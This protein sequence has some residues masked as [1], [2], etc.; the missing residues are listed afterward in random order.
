MAAVAGGRVEVSGLRRRSPQGDAAFADLLGRMGCTVT[1]RRRRT[2]RRARRR[3][4]RCAASTSTWPTSP[5]SC[6]RWPRWPLTAATPTTITRRRLHPGQGERPPRRPRRR[7]GQGSAPAVDVHADG[8]RDRARRHG[9]TAPCWRPTTTTAWRWRSACSAPSS[10]GIVVAD[11]DVVSKSWPDVLGRCSTGLACVTPTVVAAFDVDGTLTTRDCVVPFLRRVG[12]TAR[13]R[14]R[15]GPARAAVSSPALRAA[16]P[17]RAQGDGRRRASFT[18]RPVGDVE[19]A[20]RG[21]RR[22]DRAG[23][24]LRDD[25]VAR[26]RWHRDAGA[27]GRARVGLVRRVP[28]AARPSGSAST[29]W[30]PPSST[31]TP[32]VAARARCVGAQLPRRRE[33]RA[34]CTPGSTTTTAAAAPSSCGRTATRRATASCSPTPTTPVLGRRRRCRRP[35]P[36]RRR[37]RLVHGLV[38]TARPKQWM[39]NVLVFAAPGR[40]RRARRLAASW[41]G[42][43]LAFVAFCLAASGDLLLERRPR[44][45]GRPPPPDEALPPDR[46]RRS[47]R[48]RTAKVVGT[49]LDRRSRSA[50]PR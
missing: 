45:R 12:G 32:T 24:W 35:A 13:A 18:G 38:R 36:T 23:R 37:R 49:V 21:V 2:G 25:T 41:A 19:A 47:C 4:C 29:A 28:P 30:S 34:A 46:R 42:R 31:S 1:R 10:P 6:R 43:C 14:R 7:A 9:C 3:R 50:S 16:R 40:G 11:P 20:G 22:H 26:L 33:G 39:K 8:L 15:A 27:P 44:R 17:R 5:I 48:S